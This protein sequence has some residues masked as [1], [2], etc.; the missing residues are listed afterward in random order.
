MVKRRVIGNPQL[1]SV[2]RSHIRQS[3][4]RTQNLVDTLI[5]KVHYSSRENRYSSSM[6]RGDPESKK[7]RSR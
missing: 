7:D 4:M 6:S 3:R 1:N 5:I 2:K